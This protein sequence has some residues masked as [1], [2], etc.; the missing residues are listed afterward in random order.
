LA[1]KVV[2]QGDIASICSRVDIDPND[3]ELRLT[4]IRIA[5][6]PDTNISR[7]GKRWV[8]DLSATR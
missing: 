4:I 3:Q 7:P 8:G 6:D 1:V 5:G 2:N